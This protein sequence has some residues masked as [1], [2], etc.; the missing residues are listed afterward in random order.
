MDG[1]T[2]VCR[3]SEQTG[4]AAPFLVLM[5][6]GVAPV[7]PVGWGFRKSSERGQQRQIKGE[8]NFAHS[9][10]RRELRLVVLALRDAAVVRTAC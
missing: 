10:G 1:K 6:G 7:V 2:D 8:E 9:Y 5:G 3:Q 4:S